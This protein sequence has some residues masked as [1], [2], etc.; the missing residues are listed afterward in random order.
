MPLVD[1]ELAFFLIK[2]A[3]YYEIKNFGANYGVLYT[4]WGISGTI[5]PIIAGIVVDRTGTYNL[6]YMI[7]AALLVVAF[8]LAIITKPLKDTK[9]VESICRVAID[10][11]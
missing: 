5:G 3:D 6:A 10:Q 11:N 8:G 4:A 7:S 2:L 1:W 9:E